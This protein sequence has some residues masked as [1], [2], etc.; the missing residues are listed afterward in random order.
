LLA[1]V[2]LAKN[3]GVSESPNASSSNLTQQPVPPS[4]HAPVDSA[5]G[6]LQLITSTGYASSSASHAQAVNTP[7]SPPVSLV[8]DPPVGPSPKE[9]QAVINPTNQ[10]TGAQPSGEEAPRPSCWHEAGEKLKQDHPTLY[11]KLEMIG[12]EYKNRSQSDPVDVLEFA[13]SKMRGNKKISRVIETTIRSILQFKEIVAAAA[14][15]DP[16]KIAPIVWRGFCVV[17]EVSCSIPEFNSHR[18]EQIH[19]INRHAWAHLPSLRKHL[20][21]LKP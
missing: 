8:V 9:S 12:S 15:F 18:L 10:Q 16:H 11:K 14:N 7:V 3:R 1:H 2:R 4:L 17:L 20:Q 5:N 21:I 19:S 13:E 6:G